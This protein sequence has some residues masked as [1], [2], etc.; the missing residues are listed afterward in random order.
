MKNE[1]FSAL[2]KKPDSIFNLSAGA[3]YRA[4]TYFGLCLRPLRHAS[5]ATLGEWGSARVYLCSRRGGIIKQKDNLLMELI[6]V[7]DGERV[8]FAVSADAAEFTIH[9]PYGRICFCFAEN[10]LMLVRGEGGLGLALWQELETHRIVRARGEKSAEFSFPYLCS[11][12]YTPV[13]GTVRLDADWDYENL[14]SILHSAV[15]EPDQNGTFEAAIEEFTHFGCVRASY[16]D[17]ETGKAG[18]AKDFEDYL[19]KMPQLSGEFEALRRKAAYNT[20]SSLVS[21][22]GRIKRTY[23]Y[24]Y[25]S[26]P[27][28]SW[29]M[30]ANAVSLKNNLPLG[31]ELLLTMI[32]RQ[33]ENGQLP[34]FY[35]DVRNWDRCIKPPVQGWALEIL[36][37]EH[38]FGKEMPREKLLSIY[39]GFS[40]WA[41]WFMKYRDDDGDGIPQYEHGDETGNDDNLLFRSDSKL[42]LPDLSALLALLFD[43]L[44]AIARLL[45]KPEEADSWRERSR[46]LIEKMIRTFW[47]GERFVGR[48]YGD[49]RIVDDTSLQ[50]YR[51][52]VLGKRLPQE[53]IDKMAD[54]LSREGYFLTPYG[55]MAE[56]LTA[57]NYNRSAF[58]RGAITPMDNL[59]V[60]TGLYSAGKTELAKEAARRY[61]RGVLG[62][63]TPFYPAQA[64][65]P[66]SWNASAFQI[67]ADLACNLP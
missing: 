18:A 59:L 58:G 40:K 50:F 11:L 31:T 36:M 4:G 67:L 24:M 27:A 14:S 26:M 22:S 38:D 49:H 53:I 42:E 63:D 23:L 57:A 60:I 65:F 6:P 29:Q 37:R 51:T 20:W 15:I 45:E 61:C 12:V 28:S 17:Y 56:S 30:A 2:S 41:N 47:N 55:F 34:D 48:T 1:V 19:S 33:S 32:D 3:F 39:E 52:L 35:D 21:P 9:T 66:A 54:D 46:V 5:G 64:G 10:A 44:G 13:R 62:A 8:P 25:P 16:P 43:Q 7:K